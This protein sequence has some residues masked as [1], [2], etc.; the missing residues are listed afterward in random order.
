M[1]TGPTTINDIYA[2]GSTNGTTIVGNRSLQGSNQDWTWCAATYDGSNVS[3]FSSWGSP[4]SISAPT[5]WNN[6]PTVGI[7]K[8]TNS[9]DPYTGRMFFA[10]SLSS[11]ITSTTF[12][13]FKVDMEKLLSSTIPFFPAVIFEGNSLTIG[14]A[15]GSNWPTKLLSKSGWN[16]PNIKTQNYA[17]NGQEQTVEIEPRLTTIINTWAPYGTEDRLLFLWSGTNDITASKSAADI[18]ASLE[19][20]L[21]AAKAARFR[22][23]ILTI[24]NAGSWGAG[25]KKTVQNT[26]NNWILTTGAS[27]ADQALNLDIIGATYPAFLDPNDSTYYADST[28]HN[29]AGRVLIAD[30]VAANVNAP[31]YTPF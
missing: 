14:G 30:F 1:T 26:V 10:A 19:R 9:A 27:I 17:Q 5:L 23:V 20:Y 8:L 7:G 2:R 6:N 4:A 28:H 25:P 13:A 12:N 18:I 31:T 11:G 3:A 15:G 22:M 29:D 21:I 24:T 16:D